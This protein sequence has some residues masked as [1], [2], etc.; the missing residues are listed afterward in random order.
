MRARDVAR[1]K[2]YTR[3]TIAVVVLS[4]VAFVFSRAAVRMFERYQGASVAGAAASSDV[5]EL[6]DRKEDL[7]GR[8]ARLST[9]RGMEEAL[10]HRYGVAR[11]GEGVIEIVEVAPP[12]DEPLEEGGIVG[13]FKRLF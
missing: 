4:A 2:L 10:R 6:R 8:I 5:Q 3:R 13:W 9:D 7:E 12:P 1:I 11:E